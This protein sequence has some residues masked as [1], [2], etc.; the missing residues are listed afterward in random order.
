MNLVNKLGIASVIGLAG[1]LSGC[2]M[3]DEEFVGTAAGVLAPYSKD[4]RGAVALNNMGNSLVT[5]SAAERGKPEVNTNVNINQAN[6]NVPIQRP[7]SFADSGR[8]RFFTATQLYEDV[9]RNGVIDEQDFGEIK[10]V[11][12]L[13]EFVWPTIYIPHSEEQIITTTFYVLKT[14]EKYSAHHQM[15]ATQCIL[16]N[17]FS[18]KPDQVGTFRMEWSRNNR[19]LGETTFEVKE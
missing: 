6:P 5:L 12:H 17:K 14:N 18:F 8:F 15:T 9:N 7:Y 3:T 2:G 4:A 13:G 11:F 1:A 10:T 19:V 16:Q